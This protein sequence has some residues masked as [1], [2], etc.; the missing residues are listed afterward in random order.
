MSFY[1]LLFSAGI[2]SS[3]LL[4]TACSSSHRGPAPRKPMDTHGKSAEYVRGA[5]DGCATANGDYTKDHEAFNADVQYH[6][7]WFAGRRYCQL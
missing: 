5:E 2:I 4:F 1:R 3:A 7:G 6:E